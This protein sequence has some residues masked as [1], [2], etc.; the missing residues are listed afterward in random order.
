MAATHLVPLRVHFQGARSE[1]YELVFKDVPEAKAS[2]LQAG[3][4]SA[5][6]AA[7]MLKGQCKTKITLAQHQQKEKKK[8]KRPTVAA[9]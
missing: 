5:S 8:K 1:F 9:E 6:G 4:R 3:G 2:D 7:L